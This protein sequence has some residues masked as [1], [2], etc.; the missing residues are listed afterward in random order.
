MRNSVKI[1]CLFTVFAIV[2]ACVQFTPTLSEQGIVRTEIQ[3]SKPVSI[4]HATVYREDS[5]TVV[6][7]E[8]A[9][10]SWNSFGH[11][12]GHIDLDIA[13]PNGNMIERRNVS[14][15][16]KRIPKTR[17]RRA[18]FVS[19][20]SDDPPKGTIVRISYHDGKHEKSS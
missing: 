14:L 4:T 5:M 12:T 7:G 20:F 16:R 18:F 1:L 2:S 11:F 9:F 3:E 10:P 19:R 13:F 15:I 6:R 17:G 8:A